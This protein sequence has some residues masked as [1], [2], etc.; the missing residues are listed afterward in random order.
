V[1]VISDLPLHVDACSLT[2]DDP[3]HAHFT[4]V[5][6]TVFLTFCHHLVAPPALSV[7]VKV[8]VEL[9]TFAATLEQTDSVALPH[10]F[11]SLLLCHLLCP[12][13]LQAAR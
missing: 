1:N 12:L 4:E 9:A 5:E 10:R 3:A 2:V 13:Y 7:R 8:E 11:L 6:V